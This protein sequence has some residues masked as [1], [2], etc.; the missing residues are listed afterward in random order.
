V[1]R[2][3]WE[4]AVQNS[5]GYGKKKMA[6]TSRVQNSRGPIEKEGENSHS[7][8]VGSDV[9][10]RG[11]AQEKNHAGTDMRGGNKVKGRVMGEKRQIT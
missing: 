4:T 10:G 1:G 5:W 11:E 3:G 6:D 2:Y 8:G 9:P 7:G